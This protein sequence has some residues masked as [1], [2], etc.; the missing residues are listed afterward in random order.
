MNINRKKQLLEGIQDGQNA[1]DIGL[2]A[3]D[4]AAMDDLVERDRAFY[5]RLRKAGV[6]ELARLQQLA[7]ADCGE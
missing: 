6:Q 1:M 3:V 4:V 2:L 5:Y 7:G